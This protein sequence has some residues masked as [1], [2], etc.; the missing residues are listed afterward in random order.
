M[1]NLHHR[2]IAR[3]ELLVTIDASRTIRSRRRISMYSSRAINR[4]TRFETTPISPA[5]DV[6]KAIASI[7]TLQLIDDRDVALEENFYTVVV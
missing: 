2:A 1:I 5:C 6:R 4:E 7:I 3:Q